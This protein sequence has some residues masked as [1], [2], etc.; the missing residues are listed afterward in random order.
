MW[1]GKAVPA[2]HPKAEAWL[3]GA[4]GLAL[5][6]FFSRDP[7]TLNNLCNVGE[8]RLVKPGAGRSAAVDSFNKLPSIADGKTA[9][10]EIAPYPEITAKRGV[11]EVGRALRARRCKRDRPCCELLVTFKVDWKTARRG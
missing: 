4:E 7:E 3:I 10:S 8:P 2:R 9:R 1:R 11:Y 5:E 6:T